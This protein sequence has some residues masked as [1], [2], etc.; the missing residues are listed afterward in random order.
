MR[1]PPQQPPL[2]PVYL[3]LLQSRAA[4]P[5]QG[6]ALSGTPVPGRSVERVAP[7]ANHRLPRG[8][9]IDIKA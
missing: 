5:S 1:V 8:S 7:P 2:P 6:V 3:N 9:L 4:R